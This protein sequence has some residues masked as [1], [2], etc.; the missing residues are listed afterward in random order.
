MNLCSPN[1]VPNRQFMRALRRAAGVRFGLPA[2]TPMLEAGAIFLRTESELILKSR[3]VVPGKL[4]AAGFDFEF[5]EWGAAAE[6]L[7]ARFPTG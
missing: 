7:C 6:D 3:R 2:T 5:P 1:P 4:A